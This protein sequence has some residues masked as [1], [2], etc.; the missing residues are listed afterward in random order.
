[1]DNKKVVGAFNKFKSGA[2]ITVGC[3]PDDPIANGLLNDLFDTVALE[4]RTQPTL[5]WVDEIVKEETAL[6]LSDQTERPH[7]DL[8]DLGVFIRDRIKAHLTKKANK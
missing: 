8:Q 5:A 6:A 7:E 4:S 1:M 3:E 2:M